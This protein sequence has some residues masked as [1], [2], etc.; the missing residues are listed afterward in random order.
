LRIIARGRRPLS[1]PAR[2]ACPVQIRTFGGDL[3]GEP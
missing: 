3:R 1:F 2:V